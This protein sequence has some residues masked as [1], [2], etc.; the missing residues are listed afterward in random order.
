MTIL[1]GRFA[2]LT[3]TGLI[4]CDRPEG[5]PAQFPAELPEALNLVPA[6]TSAAAVVRFSADGFSPQRVDIEAGET[7]VFANQAR[8]LV[9][10]AS[11]IPP[12]HAIYP[13]F[14]SRGVIP[15]GEAWAMIFERPGFWRYHNHLLPSQTGLV[16]V[17]G[18]DEVAARA[19]LSRVEPEDVRFETL[20]PLSR[21]ETMKLYEDDVLLTE[22]IRR[23][24]PA[25]IVHQLAT[26]SSRVKGG[27]HQR[28]HEVG[29]IGYELFGAHALSVSGHECHSGSFHGATEALFRERG[30]LDLESDIE[31]LCGSA[32]NRFFR[33]QC[34]HG[35]GHGLMA[36]TSYEL[37]DAL[38]LCDHVGEP[39]DRRSCYSGVFMENVVGGLSGMMGHVTQY[40][41][42]DPHYPCN[43]LDERYAS[44]CYFYQ[45]SRMAAL[46][47]NDF[48]R[49]AEACA[50]APEQ[51]RRLCY[52]SMGRDVASV[53]RQ[54][55]KKAIRRCDEVEDPTDRRNC[56]V[57]AV[58]DYFW[59]AS[60]AGLAV[61]FCTRL[62]SADDKKACYRTI[63]SRA[64]SLP[65]SAA[66][67]RSFCQQVEEP[68]RTGC[69]G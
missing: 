7:V 45:T 19:A 16:V 12:T 42:D 13:D 55:P 43:I 21:R 2:W 10:P 26:Q 14:D 63:F 56:L 62:K 31:V 57:G 46:F 29:R 52:Q 51:A 32:P 30:T 27:C 61:E 37:P 38:G 5:A 11:H 33:H 28:A 20:E 58:Q 25:A 65:I 15:A 68:Y 64:K 53:S 22:F 36:W 69:P 6:A 9:W 23:Y 1:A 49:V 48:E 24:G 35:V 4:A 47:D 39:R 59:D 8:A 17:R 50:E 34:M 40:L 44:D 66:E 54:K 41:S 18:E 67:L 3:L 60:G